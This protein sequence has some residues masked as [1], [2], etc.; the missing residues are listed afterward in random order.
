MAIGRPD[1]QSLA[2]PPSPGRAI[3]PLSGQSGY[4]KPIMSALFRRFRSD[5]SVVDP[6]NTA[7]GESPA[8]TS[9]PAPPSDL[10]F[11]VVNSH[12]VSAVTE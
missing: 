9:R 11:R 8:E 2:V 1:L 10:G 6:S 12:R 7:E 4:R 5:K 3:S